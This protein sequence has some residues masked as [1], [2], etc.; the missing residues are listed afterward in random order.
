MAYPDVVPSGARINTTPQVDLHPADHL[1]IHAALTGIITELGNGPAGS[2][3]NVEARL[4]AGDVRAAPFQ[5]W[6]TVFLTGG[7][8]GVLAARTIPHPLGSTLPSKLVSCVAQ[9]KG[10]SGEASQYTN[11]V[12][13]GFNVYVSLPGA[14]RCSVTIDYDPT[15]V[16]P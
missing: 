12:V 5:R 8:P 15:E 11:T 6:R 1:A 10:P 2:E 13:D 16:W 14:S 3:A 9:H 7:S 4:D